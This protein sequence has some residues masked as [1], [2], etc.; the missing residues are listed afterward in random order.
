MRT[1]HPSHAVLSQYGRGAQTYAQQTGFANKRGMPFGN[2]LPQ[3]RDMSRTRTLG[4]QRRRQ[5]RNQA[6]EKFL[7]LGQRNGVKF[8]FGG[9]VVAAAGSAKI[10]LG[11][12][13]IL[14]VAAM[15]ATGVLHQVLNRH[16][17]T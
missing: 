10:G 9:M 14:V 7:A 17:M 13:G 15:I 12:E 16:T 6:F 2:R 4:S 8:N 5:I 11:G 1:R 3:E